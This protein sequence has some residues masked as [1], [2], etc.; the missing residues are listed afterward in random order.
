MRREL[1]RVA[2]TRLLDLES[3]RFAA[4]AHAKLHADNSPRE[5]STDSLPVVH[6]SVAPPLPARPARPVIEEL[7]T[8]YARLDLAPQSAEVRKQE[9]FVTYAT[10]DPKLTAA[11]CDAMGNNSARPSVS[12]V[13]RH[14]KP[15]EHPLAA[16]APGVALSPDD[17]WFHGAISSLRADEL[18]VT[19]GMNLPLDRRAGLFLVRSVPGAPPT[20]CL[21]LCVLDG[22]NVMHI[23]VWR[24]PSMADCFRL[25]HLPILLLWAPCSSRPLPPPST[26]S[27]RTPAPCCPSS[28]RCP[29]FLCPITEPFFFE[30]SF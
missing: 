5:S 12:R 4:R 1:F 8:V 20:E 22:W 11:L 21:E 2:E 26:I 14:N 18:L 19:I 9:Q 27:Q 15:T 7:D 16:A 24:L 23:K 13:T 17:V 28:S 10:V 6:R 25:L 29:A 30:F 3:R